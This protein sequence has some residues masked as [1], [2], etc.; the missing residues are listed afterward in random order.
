LPL[1][2][3]PPH[4]RFHEKIYQIHENV[5]NEQAIAETPLPRPLYTQFFHS[6]FQRSWL[7]AQKQGSALFAT[8]T[9]SGTFQHF[10]DVS[11]F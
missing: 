4:T 1:S 7:Q 5:K 2:L 3:L 9:P 8:D 6:R 11:P 10:D